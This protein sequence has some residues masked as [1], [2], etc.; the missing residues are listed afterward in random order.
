MI[1]ITRGT[2]N[3]TTSIH[4]SIS[5]TNINSKNIQEQQLLLKSLTYQEESST[6]Q[7]AGMSAVEILLTCKVPCTQTE[8]LLPYL[9][10]EGNEERRME[11]S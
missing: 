1:I 11:K 5:T 7:E 4:T 6:T 9:D 2:V 8:V 3:P 10:A